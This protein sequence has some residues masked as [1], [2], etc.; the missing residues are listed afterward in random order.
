MIYT[1][2]ELKF[3]NL[4]NSFFFSKILF[5]NNIKR[6]PLYHNNAAGWHEY[7][8]FFDAGS[9]FMQQSSYREVIN[10]NKIRAKNHENW[11]IAGAKSK[12]NNSNFQHFVGRMIPMFLS[13]GAQRSIEYTKMAFR[14][15]LNLHFK[16]Y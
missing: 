2:H 12:F 13:F 8:F 15:V 7:N 1:S 6:L 4:L 16:V 5:S 14:K 3:K 11:N 9:I 10:H